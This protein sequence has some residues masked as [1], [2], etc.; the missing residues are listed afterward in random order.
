MKNILCVK[1]LLEQHSKQ[2]RRSS[3]VGAEHAVQAKEV[4]RGDTVVS[5]V[6]PSSSFVSPVKLKILI[7]S[8]QS[9]KI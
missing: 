2:K 3:E 1:I 5:A 4:L 8:K 7:I 9:P 6:E